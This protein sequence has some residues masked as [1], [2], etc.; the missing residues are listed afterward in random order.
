MM[1]AEV[2]A[3]V[4]L[5][6]FR[7]PLPSIRCCSLG[8][9][10]SVRDHGSHPQI[11]TANVTSLREVWKA[12]TFT[13]VDMTM[14]LSSPYLS[15]ATKRCFVFVS[16]VFPS[17]VQVIDDC[18]FHPCVRYGRFEKDRVVSFVPP[19]GQFE[20][21]R[22]RVPDHL[23]MNVTPPVYCNPTVSDRIQ[24][25]QSR[26]GLPLVGFREESGEWAMIE[27]GGEGAYIALSALSYL[28]PSVA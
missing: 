2:N 25:E 7:T 5:T 26:R 27:R 19:D 8:E 22:Y 24:R 21:M 23:Q 3:A 4:F 20:L 1:D 14:R 11:L 9:T 15:K 10:R 13:A 12:Q 6:D 28:C 17:L 18:S 16:T